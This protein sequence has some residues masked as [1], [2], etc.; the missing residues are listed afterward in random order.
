M[1]AEPIATPYFGFDGRGP[2]LARWLNYSD[3]LFPGT[4]WSDTP[5]GIHGA[6]YGLPSTT[7]RGPGP[8]TSVE[9]ADATTAD[10]AWV[11]F[12]GLQVVQVIPHEVHSYWHRECAASEVR[13]TGAWEVFE[14]VWLKSFAQGHLATSRHFLLEFYDDLVEVVAE[15]LIFGV[16]R[17]KI[18]Q[19]VEHDPRFVFAF[20]RR[21]QCN[22]KR[23][24]I[25]GAVRDYRKY[26]S[27]ADNASNAEYATKCAD[28][29]ERAG[30]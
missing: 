15:G 1:K 16:G 19:V 9:V 3:L 6:E 26:A 25:E 27:V 13:K 8:W 24:D 22:E 17:F 23:K 7:A 4:F 30:Q 12:H 29:L 2:T 5:D 18:E 11:I 21:A 28:H 14:S 10:R 20:L